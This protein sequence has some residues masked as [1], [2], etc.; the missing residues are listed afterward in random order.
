MLE[1]IFLRERPVL[2]AYEVWT[3]ITVTDCWNPISCEVSFGLVDNR[4]GLGIAQLV[5]L[6]PVEK[7]HTVTKWL[8]LWSSQNLD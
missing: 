8:L 2:L 3:V 6:N 4:G 7:W 1:T 5:N